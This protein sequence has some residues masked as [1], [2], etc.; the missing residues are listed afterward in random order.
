MAVPED[1]SVSYLKAHMSKLDEQQSTGPPPELYPVKKSKDLI[2]YEK[3]IKYF[4]NVSFEVPIRLDQKDAIAYLLYE[5]KLDTIE[6]L[7]DY[8][9]VDEVSDEEFD[10]KTKKI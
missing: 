10:K 5:K 8:F 3:W 2:H 7:A 1:E 9:E 6:A 4:R